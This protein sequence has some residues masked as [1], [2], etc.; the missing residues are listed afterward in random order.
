MS[1]AISWE[2]Q[3]FAWGVPGRPW[4]GDPVD[5]SADAALRRQRKAS[6]LQVAKDT[7]EVREDIERV[8]GSDEQLAQFGHLLDDE[9]LEVEFN[10]REPREV[11]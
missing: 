2:E 11:S 7:G 3:V 8:S 9:R 10:W 5:G 1:V 4:A 6:C